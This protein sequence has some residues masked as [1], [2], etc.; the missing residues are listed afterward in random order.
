MVGNDRRGVGAREI[1][2]VGEEAWAANEPRIDRLSFEVH[3][4]NKRGAKH[5]ILS[6]VKLPDGDAPTRQKAVLQKS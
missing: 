5:D 4:F 6:V 2:K 3:S 1:L